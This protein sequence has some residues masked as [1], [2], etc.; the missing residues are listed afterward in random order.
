M[1]TEFTAPCANPVF[2][3]TY[4]R[5]IG[6]KRES[7][8]EVCDRTISGLTKLGKFTPDETDLVRSMM[9]KLHYLPSGRW[10]WIGGTEWIEKPENFLGAYNCTSLI[11][12]KLDR[13]GL[14]MNLLMMG[15][16]AGAVVESDI[17][18]LLPKVRNHIELEVVGNPGDKPRCDRTEVWME[19]TGAYIVVGDSRQGW[20]EAYQ[21]LIN[22]AFNLYL[23]DR[24]KVTIDLSHVRASGQPIKGFGGVSNPER[25]E[26]LFVTANRILNRAVGRSLTVEEVILLIDE[27]A[28]TVVAGNVRRSACIKQH[29][30]EQPLMKLNLWK[31]TDG[32]WSID[33]ERDALRMSNHTVVYHRKPTL[34]QVIEAVRLQHQC[35]EGAIQWAGEAIARSSC[36]VLEG[37]KKERFLALYDRHPERAINYL[38]ALGADN[39]EHRMNRYGLNP[40]GELVGVDFACNLSEVN[41]NTIDP[42]DFLAQRKALQASALTVAALLHHD[43]SA[44]DPIMAK[45][46]IVDPLVSV[47]ITGLFD[48]FVEAFGADYLKWWGA[49]R[50]QAWGEEQYY[51]NPVY[52]ASSTSTSYEFQSQ[53]YIQAERTFLSGW[54]DI[55]HMYVWDYCDRHN[56]KRPS[57]CTALQPSGCLTKDA[58]RIFDQGLLYADEHMAEAAGEVNLESFNLSVRQG[59]GVRT[60]IANQPLELI[61]VTLFNNRTLTL[62]PNHRLSI[63]GE[64]ISAEHLEEGMLIDFSLGEYTSASESFLDYV[65]VCNTGKGRP[66]R[67]C[68]LPSKMSPR[69]AYFIGAIFGNGCFSED[70]YRIR[71]SH[72]NKAVLERLSDIAY[73]LFSLQGCLNEDSRGGKYELCF[74]NKQL[75]NWFKANELDKDCSS[76]N[77][78]RIPLKLRLSSR[79]SIL[80]FFAGLIDTDGCIRKVGALSIDSASENFIRHLQQI[81]EAVGLCFSVYVNDKGG[82]WQ[83]KKMMFGLCLSRSLSELEAIAYLNQFSVKASNRP[84][85]EAIPCTQKFNPYS[86]KKIEHGITDCTY[87]YAVEGEDDN[88]SWYWQGC[89]KSHNTKSLLTNAS[90]GW[91]PG[92]PAD[93]SRYIRRITFRRDDPV[94]L[95]CLDYG[96]NVIP[97]Q[98]D[99]DESGAL[100]DDPFDPRCT[101]WLVE[102]PVKAKWADV[103]DSAGVDVADFSAVA[104]LDFYMQVQKY[105]TTYNTSGTISL[106]EE[107]IVEIAT[108][109]HRLIEEDEGYV[110]VALI[111][112]DKSVL[113]RLPYEILSEEQY[114][115]AIAQVKSRR[116]SEDFQ[117]LLAQYDTQELIE[118]GPAACDSEQCLIPS[119][120]P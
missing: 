41:L 9:S 16:G 5:R 118:A 87:D 11:I 67:G 24:A 86:I 48:F 94:A 92:H 43:F 62:T 109:L 12:D 99:K 8:Q 78:D 76:K 31:E 47:C 56:L 17:I 54:R 79:K 68:S 103:A 82:N 111:P 81:G 115:N 13:I 90:P 105:Y 7:F 98:A 19:P 85:K 108:E 55:V 84:I 75:F 26:G 89:L 101:E 63:S 61:K 116:K 6:G 65:P 119:N 22:S 40:C 21:N 110:S 25:L 57:R 96:Y 83:E 36:D 77:L 2:Y 15:C 10:L 71:I 30:V 91:S 50:P 107:E 102:I 59:V 70:K 64:W 112:K 4:S 35:G 33:P 1:T 29:S 88:D 14:T 38:A 72:G 53:Y 69:L 37:E 51:A 97:G 66:P 80:A 28:K 44:T 73:E 3:R 106:T 60:G 34:E 100:L 120:H 58:L 117:S 114:Q 113:P 27:S 39:L 46:R 20:V 74:S 18:A 23:L 42:G 52:F 95:A 49:G 104:K 32:K 45:S 93:S